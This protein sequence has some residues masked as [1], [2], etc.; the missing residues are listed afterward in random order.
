M[1]VALPRNYNVMWHLNFYFFFSFSSSTTGN[2]LF[3]LDHADFDFYLPQVLYM[4]IHIHELSEVLR[5]YIVDRW[6]QS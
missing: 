4:F 6:V 5:P 1:F 3:S 2:K